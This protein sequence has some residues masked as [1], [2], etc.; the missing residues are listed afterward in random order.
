[1]STADDTVS[2]WLS[3]ANVLLGLWLFAVPTFVRGATG[4][5]YWNDL[6]VGAAIAVL[7]AYGVYEASDA[8]AVRWSNGFAALLGLWTVA[9]AFVW[10]MTG[11]AFWSAAVAGALVA[12]FG[13]YNA[14]AGTERTRETATAAT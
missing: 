8:D 11:L 7:G 13:G 14:F 3:G 6:I 12:L 10:G 2:K 9:A 1:M 4:A 5:G